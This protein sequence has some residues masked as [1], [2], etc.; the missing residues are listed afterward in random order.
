MIVIAIL[1]FSPCLAAEDISALI[2]NGNKI[3]ASKA[4][5]SIPS[6]ENISP[7][8]T[9]EIAG[10]YMS[11]GRYDE[12]IN[13]YKKCMAGSFDRD[14]FEGITVSYL[15]SGRLIESSR[16]VDELT[17]SN[18]AEAGKIKYRFCVIL[19][20]HGRM[21]E[22]RDILEGMLKK[23]SED[24]DA[25]LG[26]AKILEIEKKYD[27]AGAII[28]KLLSRKDK[29]VDA[30]FAKGELLEAQGKY[31]E[32]YYIYD[33]VSKLYPGNQG[34][35]NLKERALVNMGSTSLARE[36]LTGLNDKV[37]P[38]IKDMISGNEAMDRI[39]WLEYK[40][41][42]SLLDRN[43][44]YAQ[45][46]APVFNDD[47]AKRTNFD[48]IMALRQNEDY[49]EVI[50]QYE[51]LRGDVPPW[52]TVAAADSYL[53]MQEPETALKL[54]RS[55]LAAG[56]DSPNTTM[57]LYY[58]LIE[59]G[60]YKEATKVLNDLDE[61]TPVQIVERGILQD[62]PLK[63]EIAVNK[64]WL[65]FYQDRFAEAQKYLESLLKRAPED[66]NI[67]TALAHAY[68][69]RGWPRRAIAEFEVI[70]QVDPK[71]TAAQIGYT[72]ALDAN[73]QGEEAR[74]YA[75]ELLRKFPKNKH[76]IRLI[77]FFKVGDMRSLSGN[78]NITHEN[79]GSR[80]RAFD[81]KL[82]QP[83]APQKSI[84][85]DYVWRNDIDKPDGLLDTI[86]RA[87]EGID[88]RLTRDLWFV[89]SISEDLGYNQT[90]RE[91]GLSGAAT[92][93][94][95]DYFTF[96][97]AYDSFTLDIPFR[98]R[99]FGV[100]G[101]EWKFT[102]Q[103]RPDEGT[104]ATGTLSYSGY[105]DSNANWSYSARLDQAVYTKAYYKARIALEGSSSMYKE[106][107]V[108]YFSPKKLY[109]FSA[110]PM[111]EQICYKRYDRLIANRVFFTEGVQWEK[112]FPSRN[113]YNIRYEQ[114]YTM[115]DTFSFL[116]GADFGRRAYDGAYTNEWNV[117]GSFKFS[118]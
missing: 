21:G 96:T 94:P 52:I 117:D 44:Q 97:S 16:Y 23:D 112:G 100:K 116:V 24:I 5:E 87:Y 47:F 37:D 4:Y 60:R 7:E 63:E 99:A 107:D 67:R 111:L 84:F 75:K 48:R 118:F 79:D 95:N 72:Y 45:K 105:T 13:L 15:N 57:A 22:A 38:K 86:A 115:S 64:G 32:A 82:D 103:V 6:K 102:S 74:K 59:L 12:A 3:E 51:S 53:Y 66:T 14:A 106:D 2:R 56:Y 88:L 27:E 20:T 70:R 18:P 54:Y 80:E 50:R 114:D 17:A 31:L 108:P 40:D 41:A 81:V 71:D 85:V 39:K 104:I 28:E 36:K 98:A 83:F 46:E 30:Y 93:Q 68:L 55:V 49:A 58:T 8:I 35:V 101:K 77:R 91:L 110:T 33:E 92:Y 76:V 9:K 109:T 11:L 26:M 10:A 25:N 61:K 1:S 62:N 34:A 43:R 89:G 113:V 78:W 73:G 65:L 29:P 69:Y 90:G 19:A 42:S